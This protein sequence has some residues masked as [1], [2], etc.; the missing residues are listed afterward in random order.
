MIIFN[1]I[2]FIDTFLEM[3]A[4][5]RAAA[6]NTLSAYKRD[7]LDFSHFLG[8]KNPMTIGQDTLVDYLSHLRKKLLTPST[9]ARRVSVLRQFYRFATAE[10]WRLDDPT[11]II[12]LPKKEKLIPKTLT[13]D[14]VTILIDGAAN[15]PEPEGI[16][17]YAMLET[18]YSTGLRVSE[19]VSL[20]MNAL[21]ADSESNTLQTMILIKGKGGQERIVPLNEPAII[22]LKNYLQIRPYF[23]AKSGD[24]G[25]KWLFP[26]T[27]HQGYLTRHRFGQLLKQLAID[28]G[29][30]PSKI[31]PHIL[32]HAFA[33]HLLRNGADLLVIQ[34]LLGHADISTTQ[35]YTHVIPDH[36]TNL[37][38]T[39]HPLSQESLLSQTISLTKLKN[40][41]Q[42]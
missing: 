41:T 5:E 35:I 17:L 33:T 4:A 23:L 7:L 34:K 32:R 29:I 22:A 18:L 37:V 27:S 24:Q 38:I 3:L 40:L 19:L 10:G 1:M 15:S 14:D 30:E 12:E 2:F 26:S 36:L 25:M 16:R 8:T 6:A 31:S 39:H 20:P 9:L 11:E 28:T 13:E 21:L 42:D